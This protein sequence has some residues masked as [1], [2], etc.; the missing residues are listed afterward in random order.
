[1]VCNFI[2]DCVRVKTE[3]S[4]TPIFGLFLIRFDD[5]LLV[6][7]SEFAYSNSVFFLSL[8]F[9]LLN[10]TAVLKFPLKK[11]THGGKKSIITSYFFISSSSSQVKRDDKPLSSFICQLSMDRKG[12]TIS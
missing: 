6:R 5:P 9:V 1:M 10:R 4:L 12:G 8:K 3:N 7:I 2:F 11:Y